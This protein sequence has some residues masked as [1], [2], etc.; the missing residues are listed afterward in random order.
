MQKYQCE[1]EEIIFIER[2]WTGQV[3]HTLFYPVAKT[4]NVGFSIAYCPG[5]RKLLKFDELKP[6][7]EP[8]T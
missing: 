2:R 7:A 6:L 4:A 1:C 8:E 3:W 5:C